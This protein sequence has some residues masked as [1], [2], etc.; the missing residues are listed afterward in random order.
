MIFDGREMGTRCAVLT[1]PFLL[2]TRHDNVIKN[3]CSLCINLL[4]LSRD[5]SASWDL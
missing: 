1:I 4:S 2:N 3:T 5:N